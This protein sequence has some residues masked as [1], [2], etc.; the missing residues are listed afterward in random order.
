MEEHPPKRR[1]VERGSDHVARDHGLYESRE[2]AGSFGDRREKLAIP[3]L[4]LPAHHAFGVHGASRQKVQHSH[5]PQKSSQPMPTKIHPRQLLGTQVSSVVQPA[6]ETASTVLA[7]AVDNGQG[8]VSELEVPMT[9]KSVYIQGYGELTMANDGVTPTITAAS[10]NNPSNLVSSPGAVTPPPAV[11]AS[12]ARD[13]ALATQ[14]AVAKQLNVVPQA[15]SPAP[16]ESATAGPAPSQTAPAPSS[17]VTPQQTGASQ[18]P[19]ALNTPGSRSQQVLSSPSTPV[20]ETPQSS[21][22][23]SSSYFSSSPVSTTNS[24]PSRTQNPAISQTLSPNNS[25]LPAT[26]NYTLS[27]KISKISLL[28][29]SCSLSP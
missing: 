9:S 29:W 1:K 20:P 12:Q 7:I 6:P 27:G 28:L 19:L 24:S 14:Q 13:E 26:S 22:G 25:Q 15:P 21:A 5:E 11:A 10:G 17:T 16:Q 8:V 23:S 3:K 4:V 18:S 2:R